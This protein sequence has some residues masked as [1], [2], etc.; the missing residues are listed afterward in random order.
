MRKL[1]GRN[2]ATNENI[3]EVSIAA[4]VNIKNPPVSEIIISVSITKITANIIPLTSPKTPPKT[5]FSVPNSLNEKILLM[6]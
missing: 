5:R 2:F 4:S 1:A 6:I 3:N